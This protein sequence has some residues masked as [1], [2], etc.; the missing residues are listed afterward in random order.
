MNGTNVLLLCLTGLL[1]VTSAAADVVPVTF[2]GV[3]GAA[4]FGYAVGPYYGTLD[5]TPDTLYCVDFANHVYAGETWLAN[6]TPLSSTD[7]SDTRYGGVP[8]AQ[9][10]YWEAAWLT[11]QYAA[12]PDAYGDIQATIWQLFVP[13]APAPSSN[14]WLDLAA[15]DYTT[16]DP[17]NFMIVTNVG[18][19]FR[20]G[21]VQEFIV[22]PPPVPEPSEIVL[23]GTVMLFLIIFMRRRLSATI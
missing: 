21:Q 2:T 12:H 10:L 13:T 3:N 8:D 18:P 9:K 7:L 15:Q 23:L 6:L 14:V 19:V 16:I 11:T 1:G 22:D 4:A 5:G 17:R 20:E